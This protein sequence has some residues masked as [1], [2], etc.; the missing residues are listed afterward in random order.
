M[1]TASDLLALA[2]GKTIGGIRRCF[3]C[4]GACGDSFCAVDHVS[5][6]FTDWP[7]VSFPQSDFVCAGC[8]IATTEPDKSDRPRMFSWVLTPRHAARFSKGE[9]PAIRAACLA[10]PDPPFA[11]VVSCSGQ[12]HLI[13][14]SPANLSADVVSI[15]FELERVTYRPAEL[16]ARLDIAKQIAA[17]CGKPSLQ[18]S[19]AHSLAIGMANYCQDFDRILSVWIGCRA[20]PLSRL[21]SYLCPK[22][23]DCRN[24]YPSTR[25]A[26]VVR[27]AEIPADVG[28]TDGPGLF[29]AI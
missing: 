10:P 19:P 4:G 17:A 25:S 6:T 16:A 7:N 9:M 28:R 24:E 26:P 29:G 14:R 21:A 22:M 11:I 18:E 1:P 20:E 8:I 15:Q 3:Y 5:G 27:R 13:Y 23:E 2:N 12:K